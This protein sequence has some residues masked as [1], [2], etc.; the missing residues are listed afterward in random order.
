MGE[1]HDPLRI[2]NLPLDIPSP[3]PFLPPAFNSPRSWPNSPPQTHTSSATNTPPD[4]PDPMSIEFILSQPPNTLDAPQKM[5]LKVHQVFG[6]FDADASDSIDREEFRNCIDELCIPMDDDELT[7]AMKEVDDDS[8]GSI[9]FEEFF[10][11][12]QG[13]AEAASKGKMMGGMALK[14]ARAMRNYNGESIREEAKRLI[15]ACAEREAEE[16]AR[17]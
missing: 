10:G 6:M 13:H 2:Y 4:K 17:R 16:R 9:N 14:F 8:S 5:K 11:W 7:A 1:R 12:Y 3:P 15:I